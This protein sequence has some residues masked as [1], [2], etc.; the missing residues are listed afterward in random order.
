MSGQPPGPKSDSS[1]RQV[2]VI[3]PGESADP[4]DLAA[5]R[6]V[7][8]LLARRRVVVVCGG[9]G[10]VMEA[11][12][13]GV[14]EA[15]GFS[16][17]ILPGSDPSSANRFLNLALP[18]G[19]GEARNALVIR[20]AQ[21]VISVGGSWGTLSELALARASGRPVI[22]LRGWRLLDGRGRALPMETAD[23]PAAAV[24]RMLEL[25]GGV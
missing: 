14:A 15:G 9:L 17:G 19:L 2:A 6:E 23:S 25:L 16:L 8:V 21:G 22:S 1:L 24:G 13:Q 12:A 3:G 7:G 11:A 20:A 5:A 4:D 18:T 10:G